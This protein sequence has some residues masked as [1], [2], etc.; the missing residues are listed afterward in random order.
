VAFHNLLDCFGGGGFTMFSGRS[1]LQPAAFVDVKRGE[2][3]RKRRV[4]GVDWNGKKSA[5]SPWSEFCD[6]EDDI[7]PTLSRVLGHGCDFPNRVCE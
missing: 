2:R 4:K 7:D 5:W 6:F 1:V 3:E